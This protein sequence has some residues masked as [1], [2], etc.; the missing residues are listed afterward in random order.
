MGYP[1]EIESALKHALHDTGAVKI[2][3]KIEERHVCAEDLIDLANM[4]KAWHGRLMRELL[5]YQSS[6]FN[7]ALTDLARDEETFSPLA[8]RSPSAQYRLA[9]SVPALVTV[10]RVKNGSIFLDLLLSDTAQELYKQILIE[11]A[12]TC[13]KRAV[14][15]TPMARRTVDLL[16]RQFRWP[17]VKGLVAASLQSAGAGPY[18]VTRL[19]ALEYEVVM[20]VDRSPRARSARPGSKR[21]KARR[22]R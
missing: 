11:T 4:V 18:Q 14:E 12:K 21:P 2:T 17:D 7:N 3:F 15:Q 9:L 13:F 20:R 22:P 16:L 6:A 10:S 8:H 1:T 19:S 5:R